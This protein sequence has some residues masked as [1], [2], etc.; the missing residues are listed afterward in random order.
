MEVQ[1]V[2]RRVAERERMR[3]ELEE[4]SGAEERMRRDRMRRRSF[5]SGDVGEMQVAE[6]L[7]RRRL[8]RCLC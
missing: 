4:G 6:G 5:G 3:G 8:H 1:A 7:G 2:R